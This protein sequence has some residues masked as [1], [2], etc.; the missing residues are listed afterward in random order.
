M[1][2]NEK[3]RSSLKELKTALSGDDTKKLQEL[4]DLKKQLQEIEDQIGKLRYQLLVERAKEITFKG[5][6][7]ALISVNDE[8]NKALKQKSDE[9]ARVKTMLKERSEYVLDQK[10]KFKKSQL[11]L[12]VP[13]FKE[14]N[15][16]H[17][18][19]EN[20]LDQKSIRFGD[21][22]SKFKFTFNSGSQTL[23]SKAK[24]ADGT[25]MFSISPA[26]A[27]ESIRE[28]LQCPI[29]YE[30]CYSPYV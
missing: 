16:S 11:L 22:D 17:L 10:K 29:C 13:Q 4:T 28:D 2:E 25:R 1:A 15:E 6:E 5:T 8:L 30:I 21:P 7:I 20:D 12:K 27:L 19:D 18:S 23:V 24:F 3:L 14:E 9:L 26:T